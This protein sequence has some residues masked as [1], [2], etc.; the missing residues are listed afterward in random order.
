MM[1]FDIWNI[2]VSNTEWFDI[3]LMFLVS[4]IYLVSRQWYDLIFDS[5]IFMVLVHFIFRI[6]EKSFL[7]IPDFVT[8]FLY[9][10]ICEIFDSYDD[11]QN[12]WNIIEI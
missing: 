5:A 11:L 9:A 12:I 4:M 6:I 7:N 1:L 10:V 2:L 8:L 3:D